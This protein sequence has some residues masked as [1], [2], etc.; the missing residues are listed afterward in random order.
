MKHNE[1]LKVA[2]L[3]MVLS[4][5]SPL[6]VLWAVRG[7]QAI[8]D[9][10]LIPLCAV[11][12]IIP[13]LGL[14]LRI[15]LAK[16]RDDTSSLVPTEIHDQREHIIVY[17]FAMLIPLFDANIGNQRDFFAVCVALIFVVFI[18]WKLNLHYV[19]L[20]FAL[21]G[22]NVFTIKVNRSTGQSITHSDTVIVLSKHNSLTA[23]MP[24]VAYRISDSVFIEK[25]VRHVARV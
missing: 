22:Y 24:I 25:E 10:I 1:G 17:L 18:F 21:F 9:S 16:K 11:L 7:T 8:S 23:E 19:N 3:L 20:I 12:V 14:G 15:L 6:F 13:N 2:R 4:S 5:L